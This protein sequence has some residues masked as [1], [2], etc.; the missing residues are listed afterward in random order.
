VSARTLQNW[1]RWAPKK[2]GRPPHSQAERVRVRKLVADELER[3][4]WQAGWRPVRGALGKQAPVRLVQEFTPA[5]KAAHRV[6][7]RHLWEACRQHIEVLH[8]GGVWSIDGTQVGR[9]DGVPIRAEV[10]RDVGARCTRDL[11]VAYSITGGTVVTLVQ[12][13]ILRQGFFPLVVVNDNGSENCNEDVEGFFERHHIIAL[14]NAPR[15]PQHNAWSERGI[16]ELKAESE[17]K[18]STPVSGLA[19]VVRRLAEAWWRIDHERWRPERAGT[20]SSGPGDKIGAQRY[21]R[22]YRERFYCAARA[23]IAHAVLACKGEREKRRATR[24]AILVTL[25]QFGEI[26]RTWGS[27]ASSRVIREG[28]T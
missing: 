7:V 3:Q 10:V 16:R 27:G 5:L 24:E 4:G 23:G 18:S 20:P 1:Q 17:L 19:E 13:A 14:S 6:R 12:H 9:D 8:E 26:R 11:A 15:T 2:L 22:A 21:T 25:E 28:I